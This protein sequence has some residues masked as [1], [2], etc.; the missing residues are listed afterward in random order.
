[1]TELTEIDCKKAF[2]DLLLKGMLLGN[3]FNVQKT[4]LLISCN[5][6]YSGKAKDVETDDRRS[7]K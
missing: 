4:K 3:T 7:V 6:I 1:M 2:F 5:E